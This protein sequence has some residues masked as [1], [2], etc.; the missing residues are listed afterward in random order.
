M[1]AAA[2]A[3]TTATATRDPSRICDL[4]CGLWQHWIL[5]PP[6]K[7]RNPTHTL[8]R[9]LCWVLNPLSHNRNSQSFIFNDEKQQ[10]GIERGNHLNI[11]IIKESQPSRFNSLCPRLQLSQEMFNTFHSLRIQGRRRKQATEQPPLCSAKAGER[12][13]C[14]PLAHLYAF[15]RNLQPLSGVSGAQTPMWGKA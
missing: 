10:K 11:K 7:A 8:T 14:L 13:L 2:A 5:H 9:K 15:S 12:D 1:R 6:S 4:C 3:C